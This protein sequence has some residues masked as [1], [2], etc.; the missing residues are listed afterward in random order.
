MTEKND[1]EIGIM[2]HKD[3]GLV[4]ILAITAPGLEVMIDGEYVPIDPVEGTVIVN[5][6]NALEM[7]TQ[8]RCK[9][10]L[11]RVQALNYERLSMVMFTDQQDESPVCNL[12]TGEVY[13]QTYKN[14]LA[15]QR[16][17]FES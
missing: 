8:G 16:K 5:F 13:Y 14:Y 1:V 3:F 9:S 7:M 17:E 4:T 2:P 11:H 6:G 15:Q 10:A 12:E